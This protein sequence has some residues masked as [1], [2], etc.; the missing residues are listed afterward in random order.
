MSQDEGAVATKD[1]KSQSADNHSAAARRVKYG[2]STALILLAMTFSCVVIVAIGSARH[3]RFDVTSTGTHTLSPRTLEILA[4]L[5]SP[6]EVFVVADFS[7]V[8]PRALD[9]VHDVLVEFDQRS[10]H[11]RFSAVDA[12][13]PEER[14]EF[15]SLIQRLTAL[16]Q[17]NLAEH[18]DAINDAVAGLAPLAG[19]LTALGNQLSQI[20][21]QL[22]SVPALAHLVEQA[23]QSAAVLRTFSRDVAALEVS[24]NRIL[25]ERIANTDLPPV[26]DAADA[27]AQPISRLTRQLEALTVYFDQLAPAIENEAP[28]TAYLVRTA[29]GNAQQ[30]RADSATLADRLDRLPALQLMA[31]VRSIQAGPTIIVAASDGATAIRFSSLFPAAT[32]TNADDT[33]VANLRFAGEELIA[34]AIASLSASDAP[35]IIF[36]HADPS[37]LLDD[38]G[39]PVSPRGEAFLGRLIDHLRLRRID[40][41]EWL[42]SVDDSP[43]NLIEIDPEARRPVVFV[44][45]SHP[46]AA[47]PE[48]AAGVVKLADATQALLDSGESLLISVEPSTLPR[49]G[50][51]DPLVESLA[52]LGVE[53][54]SGMTV[55]RRRSSPLGV[56]VF[57][58]QLLTPSDAFDHPI[59]RAIEGLDLLLPWPVAMNITEDATSA[60]P[61]L[62]L[63]ANDDVWAESEWAGFRTMA[64]AQRAMLSN[65]PAPDPQF[66]DVEGPWTLAATIDRRLNDLARNQRV[67]VVGANGWFFDEFTQQARIVDG[68]TTAKY[69]GNAELFDAAIY[70]LAGQEELIAPSPT[71]MRV[72]RIGPLT[73]GQLGALHWGFIVGLPALVLLAGASWRLLRG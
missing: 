56:S 3:V 10:E 25:E 41:R 18:R 68:V 23:S 45:I 22:E 19:Q 35:I 21:A 62:D 40:A 61:L 4:R 48:A 51:P 37:P 9:R 29:A 6:H 28:S 14:T 58:G 16:Y 13:A 72:A 43:P 5:D 2:L 54:K 64:P 47:S 33:S 46:A 49:I 17:D 8:D 57:P 7:Q 20:S 50:T 27:L 70:W 55:L 73:N 52:P 11:L 53:V 38:A 69:P 63:P 67:V 30:T 39:D 59:A 71:S 31:I 42:V 24:T 12:L 15:S 65:P 34:S 36:T 1:A 26:D 32:A 44:T 60:A 66:D